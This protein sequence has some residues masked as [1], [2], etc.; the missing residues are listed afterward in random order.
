MAAV[1][2]WLSAFAQPPRG[3]GRRRARAGRLHKRARLAPDWRRAAVRPAAWL[4]DWLLPPAAGLASVPQGVPVRQAACPVRLPQ[5]RLAPFL[6]AG[7]QA[8]CQRT[9]PSDR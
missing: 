5:A 6:A 8:P 4:A 9:R 1:I 3:P 2:G 7:H